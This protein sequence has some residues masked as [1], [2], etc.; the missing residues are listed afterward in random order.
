[1]AKVNGYFDKLEAEK[2]IYIPREV[3]V[4]TDEVY[5]FVFWILRLQ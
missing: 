2:K 1:M 3:F 5:L 4:A